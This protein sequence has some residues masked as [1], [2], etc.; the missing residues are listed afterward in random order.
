MLSTFLNTAITLYSFIRNDKYGKPEHLEGATI[1]ARIETS[2]K[3]F[4]DDLGRAMTAE[5]LIICTYE[6]ITTKNRIKIGQDFYEIIICEDL[7][8]KKSY[9]HTE[10]Y[11]RKVL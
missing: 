7:Y 3:I 10:I 6:A 8:K 9:S 5:K 4:T 1:N 11:A 2:D